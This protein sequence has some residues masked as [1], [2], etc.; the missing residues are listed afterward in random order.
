MAKVTTY[1]ELEAEVNAWEKVAVSEGVMLFDDDFNMVRSNIAR[2]KQ[3]EQK[4]LWRVREHS[5]KTLQIYPQIEFTTER[6]TRAWQSL[7][8]ELYAHPSADKAK[9]NMVA[10]TKDERAGEADTQTI[11]RIGKFLTKYLDNDNY[12]EV[13]INHMAN[14]FTKLRESNASTENGLFWAASPTD[15]VEVYKKCVVGSCMSY[16]VD[17]WSLQYRGKDNIHLSNE[18]H[19][20]LRRSIQDH[21]ETGDYL[22]PAAIYGLVPE[23]QT[24]YLMSKG[25]IVAR[26]QANTMTK[27]FVRVYGNN[28]LAQMLIKEGY[29][30]GQITPFHFPHVIVS[31]PN[32]TAGLV[33]PYL[34]TASDRAIRA[35]I[36][37]KDRVYKAHLSGSIPMNLYSTCIHPLDESRVCSE[38]NFM[39]PSNIGKIKLGE[40]IFTLCSICMKDRIGE[41]LDTCVMGLIFKNGNNTP[42]LYFDKPENFVEMP[43]A[44]H[45]LNSMTASSIFGHYNIGNRNLPTDDYLYKVRAELG[46]DQYVDEAIKNSI[47]Y[48]IHKSCIKSGEYVCRDKWTGQLIY[49]YDMRYLVNPKGIAIPTAEPA[50]K[51][52]TGTVGKA[53]QVQMVIKEAFEK[54][55]YPDYPRDAFIEINVYPQRLSRQSNPIYARRTDCVEATISLSGDKALIPKSEATLI[56]SSGRWVQQRLLRYMRSKELSMKRLEH[57]LNEMGRGILEAGQLV[58]DAIPTDIA[59]SFSD[60][61]ISVEQGLKNSYETLTY[62]F[63]TW[64]EW[65]EEI[66]ATHI[67]SKKAVHHILGEYHA[68]LTRKADRKEESPSES[69]HQERPVWTEASGDSTTSTSW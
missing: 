44:P 28:Y 13:F 35:T 66:Q 49:S 1:E 32:H 25:R 67:I 53:S 14:E 2:S 30:K 6:F 41:Y 52:I 7:P 46:Y 57:C 16:G 56:L 58:D 12:D 47:I 29:T 43:I 61:N 64:A 8:A 39:Q 27:K 59:S 10:F 60:F 33:A 34:D 54:G 15:I 24:A 45:R 55:M 23:I 50:V 51:L 40:D 5:R 21:S 4:I 48:R 20:L 19:E 69:T 37:M 36:N 22:H 18:N 63:E 9:F 26:S 31:N 17:R 65:I 68:D 3:N 42:M 62:T 38:C 11:S